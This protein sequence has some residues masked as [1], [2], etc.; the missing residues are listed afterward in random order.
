MII[1]CRRYTAASYNNF[2]F[3]LCEEV[4]RTDKRVYV[5]L[6]RDGGYSYGIVS[7]RHPNQYAELQD[8]L[9]WD[10]DEAMFEA[11][12]TCAKQAEENR[13]R[14]MREVRELLDARDRKLYAIG[15]RIES[16]AIQEQ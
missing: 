13:Q 14:L 6:I 2:R 11:M 5:T 16:L 1:V 12:L 3:A 7:G 8:V 4:R 10:A 9:S 15:Q